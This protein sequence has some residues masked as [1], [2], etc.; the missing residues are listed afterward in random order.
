MRTLKFIVNGQAIK[1][2]PECDFE[3]LTPD[4]SG[5]LRAEFSFSREWDGLV[6]VATFRSG[7]KDYEPQPLVDGCSCMIPAAVLKRPIFH[8]R[9]IGKKDET[10]LATNKVFIHQN[11]GDA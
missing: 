5:H 9:V 8:I 2:D 6:K 10:K 7:N 3:G 11:G 1:R 4:S